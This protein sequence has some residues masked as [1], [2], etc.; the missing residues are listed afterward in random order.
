M[1]SLKNPGLL[2]IDLITTMGAHVKESDSYLGRFGTGMKYAIAVLLRDNI[3][4][5]LYIGENRYE[6]YTES[7]TLRGKE[8]K[9]CFMRGPADSV[10][11]GFTTDLGRDW[12]PWMAYRELFTNC[13]IVSQLKLVE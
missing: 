5:D 2:E 8:F 4:F 12:K 3:D 9:K 7:V 10:P 11:L 6:F 13:V 1:I